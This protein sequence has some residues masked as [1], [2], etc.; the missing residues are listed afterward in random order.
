MARKV[1]Q[2]VVTVGRQSHSRHDGV[3]AHYLLSKLAGRHRSTIDVSNGHSPAKRKSY[4][5]SSASAV[6]PARRYSD[7]RR[8]VFEHLGAE[9]VIVILSKTGRLE[10]CRINHR[11]GSPRPDYPCGGPRG[12]YIQTKYLTMPTLFVTLSKNCAVF[13]AE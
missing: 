9:S 10:V 12:G 2:Q 1:G 4:L 6:L 11:L 5:K 8:M 3:G 13:N 7:P